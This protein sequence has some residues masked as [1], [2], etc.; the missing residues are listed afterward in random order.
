MKELIETKEDAEWIDCQNNTVEVYFSDELPDVNL[1]TASY[2]FVFKDGKFLQT[3]LRKGERPERR[4]D[5]PGGHIDEG[6]LP[7][8]TAIR[9]TFEETGIHVKNPRLVA[10][11]KITTHLPQSENSSRYPYPTTYMLFYLCDIL[12]EEPFEGNED[13]HGR[14]WVLPEEFETSIWCKENKILLNRVLE[15]IKELK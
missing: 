6:E 9:E 2:S 1:C 10:Y 3:E 12:N 15:Y 5:I 13:A 11:I 4:L 7:D 14:V 8:Q